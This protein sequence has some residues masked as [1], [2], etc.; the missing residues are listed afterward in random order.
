[1]LYATKHSTEESSAE[2]TGRLCSP[3]SR[4]PVYAPDVLLTPGKGVVQRVPAVLSPL[5]VG[6]PRVELTLSELQDMAARQQ[7]QI[8]NQQQMLV[9]KVSVQKPRRETGKSMF[10]KLVL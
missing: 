1:M 5:Q 4:K 9:A 10:S 2:K 8:E 6:H 3:D 7:Q